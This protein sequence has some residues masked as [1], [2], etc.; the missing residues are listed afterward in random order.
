MN[1][2]ETPFENEY[3]YKTPHLCTMLGVSRMAIWKWEQKGIFSAPRNMHG[4]RVFTKEQMAEIKKAFSP[5]GSH[6]WHFSG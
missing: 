2:L 6:E 4:D 1:K 5:R 3:V